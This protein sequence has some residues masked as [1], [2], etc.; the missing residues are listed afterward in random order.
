MNTN[1]VHVTQTITDMYIPSYYKITDQDKIED[2]IKAN[3]FGLMITEDQGRLHSTHLPFITEGNGE[4]FKL[5]SHL[6]RAN[7]QWEHLVKHEVLLVFAGPHAYISPGNY[8]KKQNVPTWNYT[9]VHLY[10]RITLL[11]EETAAV[12]VLEKT[13][14][15]FE[16]AYLAQWNDLNGEYKTGMLK[17][18]VAFEF[19]P[20]LIQGKFKLSQNKTNAEI[21][22]IIGSLGASE[23]SEDRR[24]SDTMKK[25]Y[26]S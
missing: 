12:E 23:N 7:S 18:L 26:E 16:P 5:I 13:I 6:S 20:T 10:G 4:S 11:Q 9:S 2:H 19:K 1:S 8:E 25:F 14:N 17:G 22:N 24:L 15:V 3:P 21:K